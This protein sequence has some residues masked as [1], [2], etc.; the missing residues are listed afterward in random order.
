MSPV[1]EPEEYKIGSYNEEEPRLV[2]EFSTQAAESTRRV[3][4][5]GYQTKTPETNLITGSKRFL[6]DGKHLS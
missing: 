5:E 4:L 1:V 3:G 2:R 6:S